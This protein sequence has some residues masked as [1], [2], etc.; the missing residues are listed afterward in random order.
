MGTKKQQLHM[1]Y[2]GLDFMFKYFTNMQTLET[3]IS[4]NMREQNGW[5]T[6]YDHNR[7]N[8]LNVFSNSVEM[9]PRGQ[10]SA[11]FITTYKLLGAFPHL[12]YCTKYWFINNTVLW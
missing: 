7:V 10:F 8:G 9:L 2:S 3:W 5:N 11:L 1:N 6:D 4:I 12:I